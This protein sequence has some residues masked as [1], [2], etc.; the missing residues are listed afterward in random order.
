MIPCSSKRPMAFPS[1]SRRGA[2]IRFQA[3]IH[4]RSDIVTSFRP[5]FRRSVAVLQASRTESVFALPDKF[6]AIV[7]HD[8]LVGGLAILAVG[9][10]I[11]ELQQVAVVPER[12]FTKI[13]ALPALEQAAS[14]LKCLVSGNSLGQL[15]PC[16]LDENSAPLI[17]DRRF[18]D[19]LGGNCH[20]PAWLR[21][22]GRLV[23]VANN[24]QFRQILP[25][26][27]V[28]GLEVLQRTEDFHQA[29]LGAFVAEQTVSDAIERCPR[30]P[31]MSVVDLLD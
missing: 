30:V 17:R 6:H 14:E 11:D 19:W 3:S 18:L 4:S 13:H 25:G 24:V 12:R 2:S 15:F 22:E 20:S 9:V 26:I 10:E 7:A 27:G 8:D 23:A 21:V 5:S 31:C 1:R 29:C 16:S 28:P